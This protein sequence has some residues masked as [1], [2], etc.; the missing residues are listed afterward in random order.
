M[1]RYRFPLATVLRVRRVE[2]AL[3]QQRLALS[4]RE[5]IAAED[6]VRVAQQRS[7]SVPELLLAADAAAFSDWRDR[8]ERAALG[9]ASAELIVTATSERR[10]ELRSEA[11]TAES[12]VRLLERLEEHRRAQWQRDE[13][14]AD[15]AALDDFA[16]V[17]SA[18]IALERLRDA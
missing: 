12:R 13:A 3:A 14:R 4:T 7:R 11:A 9:L 16:T 6:E 15:A 17:R 2:S 10:E 1:K 8:G 18:G 5:L